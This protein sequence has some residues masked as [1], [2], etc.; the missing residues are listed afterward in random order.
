MGQLT[1]HENHLITLNQILLWYPLKKI[2]YMCT[3]VCV[4]VMYVYMYTH[5]HIIYVLMQD[6]YYY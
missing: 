6:T 3:R 2:I 1:R 5:I 4:C